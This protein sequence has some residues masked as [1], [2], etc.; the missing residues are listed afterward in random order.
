MS[1]YAA[2]PVRCSAAARSAR[3]AAS[4]CSTG[5]RTRDLRGTAPTR[6]GARTPESTRQDCF[7][8]DDADG[9][10]GLPRRA[11]Q[12]AGGGAAQD[13]LYASPWLHAFLTSQC[14][15]PIVPSGNRGSYSYYVEPGDHLD[16]HLDID[17]CDVT[18]ITVLQDDTDP[19]ASRGGSPVY[20]AR[21]GLA[22][23]DPRGA[24]GGHRARQ[25]APGQSIVILGG[26]VPHRV[27]PLGA[28]GQRVIS[29]L[30]FRARI[31]NALERSQGTCVP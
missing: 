18:L 11:L 10:G 6:P 21:L 3:P 2:D 26:L 23:P 31:C 5:C 28:R 9:R 12:T 1:V 14:G 7:E 4:P 27:V 29:A 25:G 20:P 19:G 17:T 30:C 15:L 22:Q 8:G 24:R 16:T 13:A